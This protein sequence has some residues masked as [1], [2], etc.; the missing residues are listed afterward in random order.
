[1][2]LQPPGH[3][4]VI[5]H[6]TARCRS[7]DGHR[8]DGDYIPAL[9]QSALL[10]TYCSTTL[11][12]DI[13]ALADVFRPGGAP[14]PSRPHARAAGLSAPALDADADEV[15]LAASAEAAAG[16]A[17]GRGGRARGNGRGRRRPCVQP[18]ADAMTGVD[19]SALGPP[20]PVAPPQPAPSAAAFASDLSTELK[21]R[22]YTLQ[23]A[24]PQIRGALRQALRAGLELV[25]DA[26]E[27][28][29]GWK[30]FL[31][32]PRML[33]FRERGQARVSPQEL[34]KRVEL[35][36]QDRWDE[37]LCQAAQAAQAAPRQQHSRA[38]PQTRSGGPA[39]AAD[40]EAQRR[41]ER[42]VAL[43]HLGELSAARA[44]LDATPLAPATNETLAVLRDPT[45][46]PQNQP[47]ATS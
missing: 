35:L 10:Q 47:S 2:H 34:A 6:T 28:D 1:M 4:G 45:N 5:R 14:S 24:P 15:V 39:T 30:L 33:L 44:A 26:P 18:A 23:S 29:T 17:V 20:A 21:R 31:L 9:A 25:R 13:V 32:A 37:L 42:A 36:S 8:R 41:A 12:N 7:G 43:V 22:V 16:R 3:F 19:T 38:P 27:Q 11:T 40:L 46:R